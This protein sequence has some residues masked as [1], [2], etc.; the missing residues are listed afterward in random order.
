[1]ITLPATAL[2]I[3]AQTQSL[4]VDVIVT[5]SKPVCL[6]GGKMCKMM[7]C[8]MFIFYNRHYQSTAVYI[9]VAPQ[10]TDKR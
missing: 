1:M 2:S 9:I 7:S 6:F 4:D 3:T 8:Q 5:V 10:L